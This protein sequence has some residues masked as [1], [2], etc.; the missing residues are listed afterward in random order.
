M[1]IA[2]ATAKHDGNAAIA[3]TCAAGSPSLHARMLWPVGARRVRPG[4]ARS[5]RERGA[6]SCIVEGWLAPLQYSVW[7]PDNEQLQGGCSRH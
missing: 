2:T 5:R 1:G 6:R 3:G 7:R 4:V